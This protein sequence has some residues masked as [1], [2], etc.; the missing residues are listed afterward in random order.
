MT[1]ETIKPPQNISVWNRALYMLIFILLL[2][3]AKFVTIIVVIGQ[4]LTVLVYVKPNEKLLTFG[5]SLSD[6]QYQILLFLT[7][8]SEEHPYPM[9]DWP[10]S[11][12]IEKTEPEDK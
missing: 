3:V 8:N 1:K 4:F 2:G 11:D 6:Y 5:R 12:H 10:E 9:G 7:Y